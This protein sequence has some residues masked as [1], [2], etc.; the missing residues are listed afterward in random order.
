MPYTFHCETCVQRNLFLTRHFS[1]TRLFPSC[2]S[3]KLEQ[4]FVT[5]MLMTLR[6]ELTKNIAQVSSKRSIL[7]HSSLQSCFVF[8]SKAVLS[9]MFLIDAAFNR[10]NLLSQSVFHLVT[11][12]ASMWNVQ[13]VSGLPILAN[14]VHV[15]YSLRTSR[16]QFEN[17]LKVLLLH[18]TFAMHTRFVVQVGVFAATNCFPSGL[19]RFVNK[20]A[21][22]EYSETTGDILHT[23]FLTSSLAQG[24]INPQS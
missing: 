7:K 16:C 8:K 19:S 23:C 11:D 3:R 14:H 12:R 18:C 24:K 22:C 5:Q 17:V 4:L 13:R 15:L 1:E 21:C 9:G 2:T 10:A 6:L 20:C